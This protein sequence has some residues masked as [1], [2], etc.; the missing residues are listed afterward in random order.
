MLSPVAGD[1]GGRRSG[2]CTRN[3]SIGAVAGRMRGASDEACP[4]SIRR[5]HNLVAL[6]PSLLFM[7]IQYSKYL[8]LHGVYAALLGIYSPP[9]AMKRPR[10]FG[11]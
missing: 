6:P 3:T 10:C 1:A 9:I 4:P 11:N 2:W 8:G 7:Y 5:Y